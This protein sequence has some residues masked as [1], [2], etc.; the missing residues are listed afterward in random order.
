M[1]FLAYLCGVLMPFV[2]GGGFIA[3]F[4]IYSWFR[5]LVNLGLPK[6]T[7][8][9][10]AFA[11]VFAASLPTSADA[12]FTDCPTISNGQQIGLNLTDDNCVNTAGPFPPTLSFDEDFIFIQV[13]DTSGNAFFEL[14]D[15]AA[16]DPRTLIFTV[17]GSLSPPTGANCTAGCTVTGTH[18]GVPFSSFTFTNSGGVGTVG[19]GTPPV[20]TPDA[21]STPD[22]TGATD[23]GI[24][25][26]DNVTNIA[27]PTFV[28]TAPVGTLVTLFSGATQVGTQQLAAGQA[29]W[30]ITPTADLADGMQQITATAS[31]SGETSAPSGALGITI[32]TVAP[33]VTRIERFRPA[34][35]T[36]DANDITMIFVL[37][38]TDY[39]TS[40]PGI[41]PILVRLGSG[42]TFPI[43]SAGLGPTGP[44][45]RTTDPR[46][47]NYNGTLTM[48]LNGPPGFFDLAGNQVSAVMPADTQSYTLANLPN[49]PSTPDL[50]AASDSGSSSTDN[51]TNIARPTFTGTAPADALITLRIN[52]SPAGTQQ[53]SS[54]QTAWSIA[55][56]SDL[57]EGDSQITATATVGGI[58]SNPSGSLSIEYDATAPTVTLGLLT[59]S[60]GNFTTTITLS[61][62]VTGFLP[63]DFD[64][65]NATFLTFGGSGTSYNLTIRPDGPGTVSVSVPAD[66]F[67]DA[68]GNA[69][70]V[71]NTQTFSPNAAPVANAGSDQSAVSGVQVSLDGS[72]SADSDG[73]IA[74]YAWTQ[75]GGTGD[76][77]N[78]ILSDANAQNPTFTDPSVGS[79]DAAVT[80]IFELVVTDD[81]G[82]TSVADSVTITIT[83]VSNAAP[84]AN[85]GPDQSVISGTQVSLAG[86]GTDSDGTI[87]S[88]AWTR[89]GGTGD[90]ADAFASSTDQ[91]PTFTDPSVGSNDAAV[92]HIFELV[93]TDDDGATSVAD[94]VTITITPVAD[95]QAPVI[96]EIADINVDTDAGLGTASVVLEAT[97]SDDSGEV[98]SPVFSINGSTITSPFNFPIGA[99][100]VNVRAQDDA[101]NQAEPV[102]FVVTVTDKTAPDGPIIQ[103]LSVTPDGRAKLVG[104][105]EPGSTITVIY[106][107]AST[108]SVTADPDTGLFTATSQ[109]AQQ[110][111]TITLT[112]TDT[113]GNVSTAVNLAFFG[114]DTGPTIEIGSLSG[115]INGRYVAV[116]TL[117]EGSTEFDVSDLTLG[118]ATATLS[119]GGDT[120]SATLI[121]TANGTVTLSVAS[122]TFVDAAGN[123][124]EASN[125]VSA[126]FDGTGPTV[127]ISG[128]PEN[129]VADGMFSVT[130]TFSDAVTGFSPTDI[131][132]NNASLT[133]LGGSGSSYAAMLRASGGGN[134]QISVPADIAVDAAGNG[135]LASNQVNIADVTVER[136]QTLIASYMQTRA[137]QLI[138]SQPSLISLLSGTARGKFNFAATQGTGGIDLSNGGKYPVWVQ[139]N[140]TWAADGTSR[141]EYAF[142]ALGT[143][144]TINN[145]L[146]VGAMLQFDHLSETNGLASVS[147]TGWMAGPYFVARSSEHPLY[148]EGRFLYGETSN[149]ISPFGTYEDHFDTKRMLAQFKVAGELY[150]GLTTLT[151]FIDTSYTTD[152]QQSYLDGRG[153]A[154]LEQGISLGQ[155]EIGLDFSRMLPVSIGELELW[156]GISGIW[157]HTSGSGYASAVAPDYRGGRAR[158]EFG[159]TRTVSANQSFTAATFYDGI[160]AG[161]FESYGLSLGLEM[162]F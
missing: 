70:T 42:E 47:A 48:V 122:G 43:D 160:G 14:Q 58:T 30:S 51:L 5:S 85:A 123:A 25:L 103:T 141:S 35:E 66:G 44:Q 101:G 117:S 129:L 133:S 113:A 76:P 45:P 142:G 118:N 46:I 22:M 26:S 89:T 151:P 65:V 20:E 88:Y 137:N 39:Y 36:T 143:H 23:T 27:R 54:G 119:G 161:G 3:K 11:F 67:V 68:A 2:R 60:G 106:P 144:W 93:V 111:G 134:V 147:G 99:T 38:E 105:A 55:P 63:N 138:R 121:P 64:V 59:E 29:D 136:T 97:V 132:V 84:V 116:I 102:I 24:M 69:N 94:S 81:D 61:E 154:I 146:L 7:L 34:I 21:P 110:S 15:F 17:N 92:T 13:S 56:S 86:A 6:A 77:A 57:I 9:T 128:A 104:S 98:I 130:I 79:N 87:A 152:D 140:G 12:D 32:D 115:P 83:P 91:N 62:N 108:G 131:D 53:L 73:T 127:S 78:A 40:A 28:G 155:I 145:N 37:S 149:K 80:H 95:T 82:A 158:G 112:S 157:S 153:N 72:G 96:A 52:G 33:T 148:F 4:A 125:V 120:Y 135:N 75:T 100:T 1:T 126:I 71:S 8:V 18:G 10:A 16:D 159:V 50:A 90:V 114:D 49:T 41:N 107:D 19:G 162:K 139:V 109:R 124:N 150:H 156:G 31:A 74:S